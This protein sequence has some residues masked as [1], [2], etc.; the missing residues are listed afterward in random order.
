MSATTGVLKAARIARLENFMV[1]M[2]FSF[3]KHL[4]E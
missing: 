4:V 1:A 3:A 2:P